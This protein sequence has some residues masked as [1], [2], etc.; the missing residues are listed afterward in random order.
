MWFKKLTC[1]HYGLV[2]KQPFVKLSEREKIQITVYCFRSYYILRKTNQLRIIFT[3]S[4]FP[5]K[6]LKIFI[7]TNR[8]EF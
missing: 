2:S 5:K 4:N 1:Y 6:S 8:N 3:V 7:C